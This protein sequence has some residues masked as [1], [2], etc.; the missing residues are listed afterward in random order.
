MGIE[1]YD[2]A[3]PD[4]Q[5]EKEVTVKD[6]LADKKQSALFGEFVKSK[7]PG[8]KGGEITERLMQ[9]ASTPEDVKTLTEQRDNFLKQQKEVQRVSKALTPDLLKRLSG[10]SEDLNTL[11]KAGSVEGVRGAVVSQLEML[12]MKEPDRFDTMVEAYDQLIEKTSEINKEIEEM[13]KEHNID[14]DEYLKIIENPDFVLT[15]SGFF[16]INSITKFTAKSKF[17]SILVCT[18]IKI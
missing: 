6:I 12:A 17:T 1:H 16:L 3:V 10:Q 8:G 13:C 4:Q 18:A 14:M 5:K 11:I 9:G 2:Q 15:L 7:A